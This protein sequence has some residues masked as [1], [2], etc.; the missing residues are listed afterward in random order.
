ML[1][2]VKAIRR[3]T[4]NWAAH[5]LRVR[6]STYKHSSSDLLYWPQK[7]NIYENVSLQ[8][9]SVCN[10]FSLPIHI[11]L[12]ILSRNGGSISRLAIPTG[13]GR[14]FV[15]GVAALGGKASLCCW[16]QKPSS[17]ES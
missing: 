4:T 2:G 14:K 1:Q 8:R 16:A 11:D 7:E 10:M 9:L 12:A 3:L 13:A 5:M 17:S 6:V 15:T